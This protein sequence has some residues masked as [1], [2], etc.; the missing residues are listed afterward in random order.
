[1]ASLT[2]DSPRGALRAF[3]IRET[4]DAANIYL[5]ADWTNPMTAARGDAIVRVPVP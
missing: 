3:G 2:L 1:M 4:H 5:S